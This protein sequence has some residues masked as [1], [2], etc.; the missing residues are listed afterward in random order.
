MRLGGQLIVNPGSVCLPGYTDD[1]PVPHVM[2]TGT[3]DAS[4]AILERGAAGWSVIFRQVPYDCGRMAACA[5]ARGRED[6]AQALAP[7]W[8]RA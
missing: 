5:R 4:Y 2:Q 7:G 3:P 6:W 1:R 8:V